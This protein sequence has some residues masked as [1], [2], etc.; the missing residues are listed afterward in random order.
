MLQQ[1]PQHKHDLNGS[2]EGTTLNIELAKADN[3][4][5]FW[6]L[7]SIKC[8]HNLI[9]SAHLHNLLHHTF[10]D[11]PTLDSMHLCVNVVFS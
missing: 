9:T 7:S 6:L 10:S 2:L 8:I 3:P 1:Q 4:S 5:I 11:T